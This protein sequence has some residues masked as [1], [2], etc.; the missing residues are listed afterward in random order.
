M[1]SKSRTAAAVPK[2]RSTARRKCEGLTRRFGIA[3][4]LYSVSPLP[5][6]GQGLP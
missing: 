2:P 4:S 5:V 6:G 1:R 3:A